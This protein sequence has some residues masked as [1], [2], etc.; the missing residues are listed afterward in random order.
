M[1]SITNLQWSFPSYGGHDA[2]IDVS[3][4]FTAL[5]WTLK[6]SLIENSGESLTFTLLI[7]PEDVE[8]L[9]SVILKI[10]ETAD[11]FDIAM[12]DD[13]VEELSQ[14]LTKAIL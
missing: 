13:V 11:K 10:T 4:Y 5:G 2:Y 7:Y 9:N 3:V 12:P 1:K 6:L 14:T 8:H